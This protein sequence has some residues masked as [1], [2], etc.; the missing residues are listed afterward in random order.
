[1]LSIAD[2]EDIQALR[3]SLQAELDAD[4]GLYG[5]PTEAGRCAYC[6]RRLDAGQV[7]YCDLGCSVHD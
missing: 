2:D 4:P 1:M 3:A 7:A 5:S 6:G